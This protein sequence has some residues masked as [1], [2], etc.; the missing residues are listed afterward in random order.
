[1]LWFAAAGRDRQDGFGLPE[2]GASS[3][4]ARQRWVGNKNAR[5]LICPELHFPTLESFIPNLGQEVKRFL[6]NDTKL[7][8]LPVSAVTPRRRP[9][10]ARSRATTVLA[11]LRRIPHRSC[12]GSG[13]QTLAFLIGR[14]AISG[15]AAARAFEES[16]TTSCKCSAIERCWC[17][18]SAGFPDQA[19]KFPDGQI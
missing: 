3:Y 14:T 18:P 8:L 10:L 12:S 2:R 1:L 19:N 4:F 16:L 15:G 7:P 13:R 9:T 11:S 17:G 6:L 5:A